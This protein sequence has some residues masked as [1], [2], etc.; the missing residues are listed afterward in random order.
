LQGKERNKDN[1]KTAS[2]LKRNDEYP[3]KLFTL[4]LTLQYAKSAATK[5]NAGG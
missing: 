5:L 1:F 3:Q 2:V 4:R